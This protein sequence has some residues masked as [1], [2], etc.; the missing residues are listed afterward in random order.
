MSPDFENT[1]ALS[2]PLR[3][4]SP[5]MSYVL[6]NELYLEDSSGLIAKGSLGVEEEAEEEEEEEEEGKEED[7]GCCCVF[8]VGG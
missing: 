7:G 3:K 5:L 2:T 1:A 8:A 4:P 6:N